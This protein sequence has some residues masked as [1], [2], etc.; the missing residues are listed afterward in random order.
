MGAMTEW[1]DRDLAGIGGAGELRVAPM[2]GDG[3]LQRPRIIWVVRVGDDLFV[4][5]VNGADGA[6]FRGVQARNAGHI[7]AGGVEANVLFQAADHDLDDEIDEAYR[8]KYGR[9]S[10]AVERITS[11]EARSTTI[12]LVPS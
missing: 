2:R 9:S 7:S 10:S 5:S 11:P 8:R 6:W 3:T 1:D 12:R 4:R